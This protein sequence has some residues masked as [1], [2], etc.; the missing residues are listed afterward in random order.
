[1]FAL[2]GSVRLV[3]RACVLLQPRTAVLLA[4]LNLLVSFL[5]MIE[6]FCF[7]IQSLFLVTDLLFLY[8]RSF[9]YYLYKIPFS[10]L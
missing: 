7:W 4:N 5:S 2:L 9:I 10:A 1:M 8:Q 6:L 3:S